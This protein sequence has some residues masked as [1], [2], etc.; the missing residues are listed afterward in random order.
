MSIRTVASVLCLAQAAVWLA[1]QPGFP[2]MGDMTGE[3]DGSWLGGL[4]VL[5]P[6]AILA[7]RFATGRGSF[8]FIIWNATWSVLWAVYSSYHLDR[9][10][11]DGTANAWLLVPELFVVLHLVALGLGSA[12]LFAEANRQASAS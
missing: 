8:G 6:A 7:W 2:L 5:L 1:I 3:D 9:W 10:K 4:A 12:A 11:S